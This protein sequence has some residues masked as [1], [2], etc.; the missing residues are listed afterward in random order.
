V[1]SSGCV[2]GKY[3]DGIAAGPRSCYSIPNCSKL[4]QMQTQSTVHSALFR[5]RGSRRN[6]P[7]DLIVGS[8]PSTASNPFNS[9]G[10]A[11]FCLHPVALGAHSRAQ[12]CRDESQQAAPAAIFKP[13]ASTRRSRAPSGR[14]RDAGNRPTIG[15]KVFSFPPD[16]VTIANPGCRSE[17]RLAFSVTAESGR[18]KGQL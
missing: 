14:I 1:R 6:S 16:N 4:S 7:T 9:L 11:C 12:V 5:P 17:V 18:Q 15:T 3:V 10:S 2:R 8:H 13:Q